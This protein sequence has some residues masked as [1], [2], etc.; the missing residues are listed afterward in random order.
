MINLCLDGKIITLIAVLLNYQKDEF[1]W[2]ITITKIVYVERKTI[3]D[4]FRAVFRV[5]VDV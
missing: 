1:K 5:A 3:V 2:I 4:N